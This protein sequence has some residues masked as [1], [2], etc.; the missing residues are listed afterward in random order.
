[1]V[2]IFQ[3]N[4]QFSVR[5]PYATGRYLEISWILAQNGKLVQTQLS[6][7]EIRK[8]FISKKIQ[9]YAGFKY[10]QLMRREL[11]PFTEIDGYP[12]ELEDKDI[13]V[14][15]GGRKNKVRAS[16]KGRMRMVRSSG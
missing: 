10:K 7:T 5:I 6:S 16:P 12:H 2:G 14:C 8:Q 3:P 1:M 11:I 15:G 13:Y 4:P 9:E